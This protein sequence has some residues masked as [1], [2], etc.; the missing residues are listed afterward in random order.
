VNPPSETGQPGP[1]PTAQTGQAD[2]P[3]RGATAIGPIITLLALTT[4]LPEL[5]TGSTPLLSFLS[6]PGLLLFLVLGYGV[7]ILLV[8][9]LAVRRRLGLPGLFVLGL[10]YSIFNEGLLA[11]TLVRESHLPV[12]LYDHYGCAFGI[13]FPWA[14]AIGTW[15]ACASVLFPILLTHYFFPRTRATPWLRGRTAVGLGILLML[16]GCF[17]FLGPSDQ[18]AAGTPAQ[19]VI[20]LAMMLGLFA[21]GAGLKG[22]IGNEPAASA[23]KPAL[24]GFSVLVPFWGLGILAA[25]KP[26]VIV[27]FL[28]LAGV[29]LAYAWLLRRQRWS[30][31]PGLLFFGI[32][33]YSHNI[34]T[35]ILVIASTQKKPALAFITAAVDLLILWVL[36]RCIRQVRSPATA[37]AGG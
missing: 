3:V 13:S 15:H 17:V 33:W 37:A 35:A 26:P 8:R 18:G 5:F 2:K 4:V 14:A 16:L 36:V 30:T 28:A 22:T 12:A 27:F 29:I 6:K 10:G 23:F 7:A 20:L 11:R 24:M 34:L 21:I 32:G 25:A 1:P 19:L 9:E 31:T